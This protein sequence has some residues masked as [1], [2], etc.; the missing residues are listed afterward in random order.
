MTDASPRLAGPGLVPADFRFGVATAGFQIEGGYNGP[1]E[2]RNNW[3]RWEQA[4]RVAPSGPAIE[5]WDRYPEHLDLVAGLGCNSFR[6]SIEWARVQ[7]DDG[8]TDEAAVA[9]YRQILEAC[10]E[11]HLTPLVTLHH[12]THPHWLGEDLWLTADAPRLFA[13]WARVVIDRFGDLCSNWVSINEANVLALQSYLLGTFPPGRTGKLTQAVCALDHLTAAH[14]LA[15]D[16][17]HERQPA[18]R[19]ATNNYCLSIYE[20]DRM[21]TDLLVARDRGIERPALAAW[22]ADR[23]AEH[24]RR[25]PILGAPA[26]RALER[27]LRTVAH[28]AFPLQAAF[29]VTTDLLYA[30]ARSCLVDVA[31][32][33]YYVSATAE[34]FTRPGRKTAGGRNWLPARPLWE[35]RPHPAGLTAACEGATDLGRDVWVVENGLCNR[36]VDGRAF[37]R[38]DGWTRDRYLRENLAAV[39]AAV[40]LGVPV[41]GYWHWTL[42]DNYEWGSYEPR[43]G[44]YGVDRERGIEIL[45]HDSMGIDAAAAYRSL[46]AAMRSG[47]R[48]ALA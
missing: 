25:T 26:H 28:R 14:V 20:L 39:L 18:A 22:L 48:S 27:V 41:T 33:D 11:R 8:Y 31:Q 24:Y 40:E 32:L 46:I 35:D 16:S 4:G 44:L 7:P 38:H 19:V 42:A 17:I 15:T 5:F 2:P 3:H 21:P 34:H 9:R 10:H 1:G 45:P 6:L 30:T 37:P 43:F 13:D 36:V 47:D 12:F 29:P 23:R